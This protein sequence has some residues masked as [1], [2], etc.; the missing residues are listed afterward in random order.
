M[1]F[2]KK[3]ALDEYPALKLEAGKPVLDAVH[4]RIWEN[5]R[6]STKRGFK[7]NC[8]MIL[9]GL[10]DIIPSFFRAVKKRI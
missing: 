10:A 6:K 9:S 5:A 3:N 4:F 2:V 7:A 1:F 8:R